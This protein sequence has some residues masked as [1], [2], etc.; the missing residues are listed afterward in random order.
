MI[1]VCIAPLQTH[2]TQLGSILHV[3][4]D[5]GFPHDPVVQLVAS[6]KI[7]A[8]VSARGAALL[9]D[10]FPFAVRGQKLTIPRRVI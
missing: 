3:A 2:L 6:V 9:P 1:K 4:P 7:P 5:K 10:F 8:V